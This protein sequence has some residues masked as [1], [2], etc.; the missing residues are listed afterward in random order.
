MTD[1]ATEKYLNVHVSLIHTPFAAIPE[2]VT[3]PPPQD[4][5]PISIVVVAASA[6]GAG[7][8][9]VAII[10][11]CVIICCCRCCSSSLD[12]VESG[13][14]GRLERGGSFRLSRRKLVDPI[15]NFRSNHRTEGE[16]SLA[17][18]K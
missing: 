6:G 9:L 8:V 7:L 13:G 10:L 16:W 12:K 11:V 5:T 18:G 15:D 4:T 2:V 3:T 17:P 14:G 1:E